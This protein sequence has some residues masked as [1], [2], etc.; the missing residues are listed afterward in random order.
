GLADT[1]VDANPAAFSAGVATGFQHEAVSSH[2]LYEAIRKA[3][4]MF[5]DEKT[6]RKIQ[7]RGM[8]S[9]VSWAASAELYADLYAGLIGVKRDVDQDD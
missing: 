1:I 3:I 6:W 4:H 5:A 8:K 2:A 9:D 7:R